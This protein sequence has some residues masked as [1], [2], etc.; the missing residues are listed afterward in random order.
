MD[1]TWQC[2]DSGRRLFGPRFH[3]LPESPPH[4]RGGA[5]H[6]GF[7]AT[8]IRFRMPL[9]ERRQG[10]RRGK[11]ASGTAKIDRQILCVSLRGP[12]IATS[13]VEKEV[14]GGYRAARRRRAYD[15]GPS[16]SSVGALIAEMNALWDV[17]LA[18]A[19]T[20]E[21]GARKLAPALQ[22]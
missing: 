9:V 19:P 1:Q 2:R 16:R 20:R 17:G 10:E 11:M 22:S 14:V 6:I 18:L 7:R 8:T 3:D 4:G 15:K 21:V 13:Q 12:Q 5:V